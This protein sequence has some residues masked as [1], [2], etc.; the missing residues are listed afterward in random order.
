MTSTEVVVRLRQPP[1]VY[2]NAAPLS[3]YFRF[4]IIPRQTIAFGVTTMDAADQMVGQRAE[5]VASRQPGADDRAA[6]ERVLGDALEGDATLFARMDYVEEAWRIVDPLLTMNTRVHEYEP[7]TW[8][9]A[10]SVQD[11]MPAGGWV[12]PTAGEAVLSHG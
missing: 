3:N 6:Y 10:E 8:G 5:L 4:K 9:P 2:P 1:R 12:N 7:G 11:F